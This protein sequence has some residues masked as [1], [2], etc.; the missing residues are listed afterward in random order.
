MRG[1]E[2]CQNCNTSFDW[3]TNPDIP[4]ISTGRISNDLTC[5][6]CGQILR[7][8]YASD[9]FTIVKTNIARG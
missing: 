8:L 3:Q 7:T 2:T 9:S 1:H 5:P 6:N 4:A